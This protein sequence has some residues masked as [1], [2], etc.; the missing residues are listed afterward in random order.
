MEQL[1]IIETGV[2]DI[3]DIDKLKEFPKEYGTQRIVN[4]KNVRRIKESMEQLYVPSVIKVNQDWFILDGQHSKEA[5]KELALTNGEIAYVMYDTKGKDQDVCI[6]L[7]TTSKQWDVKDFLNVWV[8]SD[9]EDYIWFKNFWETYDLNYQSA[10]YIISGIDCGGNDKA[11]INFKNG[12]MII[13]NENRN[14]AIRIAKQ[15]QEIRLIIPKNVASQRNFHKAF[16]KMAL[17]EKYNHERMTTKLDYQVDRIRKCSNKSGYVALL[18]AI[19]NFRT[20]DKV[21]FI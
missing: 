11:T 3:K 10:M 18:Q 8:N 16:I 9:K 5:I 13:T 21:E 20:S 15:L 7:N 1:K 19:Y 2:L 12:N 17:N 14:K 6:L 4:R